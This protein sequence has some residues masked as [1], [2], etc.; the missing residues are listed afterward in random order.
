MEEEH[1]AF[2]HSTVLDYLDSF[3]STFLSI[4]IPEHCSEI[5]RKGFLPMTTTKFFQ[6]LNNRQRKESAQLQAEIDSLK[7]EFDGVPEL[8]DYFFDTRQRVFMK[9][10]DSGRATADLSELEIA[11]LK[12]YVISNGIVL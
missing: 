7:V 12:K 1:I 10:D 2:L 11:R 3:V 5:I 9:F 8:S 6:K 4:N